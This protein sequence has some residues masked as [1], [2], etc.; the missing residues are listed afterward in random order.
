MANVIDK[1]DD[2]YKK[3]KNFYNVNSPDTISSETKTI[4]Q[5]FKA[6]KDL[7]FE[8]EGHTA[9]TVDDIVSETAKSN[10]KWNIYTE[11]A[12]I[13]A[14]NK[15][16]NLKALLERRTKLEK[17]PSSRVV[18][19]NEFYDY[20]GHFIA[21]SNGGDTRLVSTSSTTLDPTIDKLIKEIRKLAQAD[22]TNSSSN[23]AVVPTGTG[24]QIYADNDKKIVGI[25]GENGE[26]MIVKK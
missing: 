12:L 15:V 13:P 11:D 24:K 17:T 20:D 3:L 10:K 21:Y 6:I 9:E 5:E 19:G 8:L 22:G 26:I 4:K 16:P 1:Y 14:T 7:L 25:A 2:Y 18:G 23:K